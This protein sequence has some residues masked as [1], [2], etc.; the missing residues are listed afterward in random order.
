[1]AFDNDTS[2]EFPPPHEYLPFVDAAETYADPLHAGRDAVWQA[3][4]QAAVYTQVDYTPAVTAPNA[5][6]L[7]VRGGLPVDAVERLV[8]LQRSLLDSPPELPERFRPEESVGFEQCEVEHAALYEQYLATSTVLEEAMEGAY[9]IDA[10]IF[11]HYSS[12]H[13]GSFMLPNGEVVPVSRTADVYV[14]SSGMLVDYWNGSGLTVH[15]ETAYGSHEVINNLVPLETTDP[16]S[17]PGTQT[18]K[19]T[20][21]YVGILQ[22]VAE[23]LA[24]PIRAAAQLRGVGPWVDT[25]LALSRPAVPPANDEAYGF[26]ELPQDIRTLLRGDVTDPEAAASLLSAICRPE[27]QAAL[28]AVLQTPV[29]QVADRLRAAGVIERYEWLM[30]HASTVQFDILTAERD[31]LNLELRPAYDAWRRDKTTAVNRYATLAE[32]LKGM[33]AEPLQRLLPASLPTAG[34]RGLGVRL[35]RMFQDN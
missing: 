32:E 33:P 35:R 21:V 9:K 5:A 19:H 22:N 24:G 20:D 8:Y 12:V 30:M 14:H 17:I 28:A 29:A 7:D 1:M 2:P 10:G 13:L 4:A 26:A 16:Q 15:T 25:Y 11:V 18:V 34:L 3:D 23:E 6:E 27:G 31:A